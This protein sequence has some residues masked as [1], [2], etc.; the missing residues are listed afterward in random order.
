MIRFR[1]PADRDES[2]PESRLRFVKDVQE[3][4]RTQASEGVDEGCQQSSRRNQTT[5]NIQ[6]VENETR[7]QQSR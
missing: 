2:F 5:Q 3:Q 7:Y 6:Y 4:Y 1:S